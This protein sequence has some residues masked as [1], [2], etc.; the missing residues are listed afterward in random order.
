MKYKSYSLVEILVASM[1]FMIVIVVSI[2]AFGMIKRSNTKA[3]DLRLTNQCARQ[4]EDYVGSQIR[5][6]NSGKRIMAIEGTSTYI[7][8]DLESEFDDHHYPGF[9]LFKSDGEFTIIYKTIDNADGI[10]YGSYRT[11]NGTYATGQD[12]DGKTIS[13]TPSSGSIIAPQSCSAFTTEAEDYILKPE[14][15]FQIRKTGPDDNTIEVVLKDA[16]YR[17]DVET[18]EISLYNKSFSGI[19]LRV[20]NSI[21]QL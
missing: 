10:N 19:F 21:K 1:I 11:Q 8:R 16:V 6:S 9:A 15:P 4:V 5:S 14:N 3:D 7:F 18:Q 2:T 12:A 17:R 20:S 13:L